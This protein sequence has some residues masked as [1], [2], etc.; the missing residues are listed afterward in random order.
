MNQSSNNELITYPHSIFIEPINNV[1]NNS[2][3]HKQGDP[4]SNP[5][6]YIL[7]E[8]NNILNY[9]NKFQNIKYQIELKVI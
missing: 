4:E 3:I 1:I 5:I 2:I 6:Q 7:E 9:L 8:Q